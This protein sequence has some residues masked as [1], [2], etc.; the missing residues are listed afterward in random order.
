MLARLSCMRPGHQLCS[1][2]RQRDL[3]CNGQTA[4]AGRCWH[5][6]GV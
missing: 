5:A 2:H 3:C 6:E 1:H 4:A